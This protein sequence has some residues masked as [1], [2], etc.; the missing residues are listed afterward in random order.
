[1]Y[2]SKWHGHSSLLII[3]NFTVAKWLTLVL[4][5]FMSSTFLVIG[6]SGAIGLLSVYQGAKK[7]GF[8]TCPLGMQ[9][10]ASMY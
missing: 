10:I 5:K 9:V 3:A 6:L 7:V 8:T 1:M 2:K 4:Y